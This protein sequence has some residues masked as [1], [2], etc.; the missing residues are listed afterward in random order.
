MEDVAARCP[1]VVVIDRGRLVYDGLLADLVRRVR[2]VKR[3]ELRLGQPVRTEDLA[4][5]GDI[6]V[7][8]SE[9][10][11]LQVPHERLPEPGSRVL[12][13]LPTID[14]SVADPPLEEVFRELYQHPTG[15]D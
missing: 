2:P 11:V 8:E 14:L 4:N 10:V 13:S 5:L 15:S 12:A 7:H 3:V 1:R 9:R 6:V